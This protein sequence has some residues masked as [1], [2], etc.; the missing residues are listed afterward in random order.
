MNRST[1]LLRSIGLGR[2]ARGRGWGLAVS[3]SHHPAA[4]IVDAVVVRHP[5]KGLA[6]A[7]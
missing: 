1:T 2:A 5:F 3:P 4:S 7:F 6:S